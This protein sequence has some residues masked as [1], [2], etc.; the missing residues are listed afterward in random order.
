MLIFI[1]KFLSLHRSCCKTVTN[2]ISVT[3]ANV[4]F[5]DALGLRTCEW[6]HHWMKP[7]PV[8]GMKTHN[9]NNLSCL[10]ILVLRCWQSA[11]RNSSNWKM[12]CLYRA[13]FDTQLC[14]MMFTYS[15]QFRHDERDFLRLAVPGRKCFFLNKIDVFSFSH[16]LALSV[17]HTLLS[18]TLPK[19]PD[20]LTA[21]LFFIL[22]LGGKEVWNI[23]PVIYC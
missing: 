21:K 15:H 16:E 10:C 9:L 20:I 23:W 17:F 18:V 6:G 12:T 11:S 5:R 8:S 2:R 4:C 13:L 19:G 14:L 22:P 1:F 3:Q 7:T